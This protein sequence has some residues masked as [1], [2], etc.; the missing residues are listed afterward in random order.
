MFIMTTSQST[1]GDRTG[2][3]RLLER[4]RIKSGERQPE[5][6]PPP[7]PPPLL[8]E[9]A[10]GGGAQAES[11]GAAATSTTSSAPGLL[12]LDEKWR[13]RMRICSAVGFVGRWFSRS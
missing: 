4:G 12:S 8:P 6:D 1:T 13:D 11:E 7:P 5:C 2:L 10:L 9:H 3:L